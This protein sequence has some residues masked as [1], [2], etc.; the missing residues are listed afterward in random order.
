MVNEDINQRMSTS[1]EKR[2]D[3]LYRRNRYEKKIVEDLQDY[4]NKTL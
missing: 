2:S 4:M 3:F 1:C